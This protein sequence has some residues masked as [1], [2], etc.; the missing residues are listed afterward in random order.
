ML[1]A[2]A[3]DAAT[4]SWVADFLRDRDITRY[5]IAE[6]DLDADGR[7][8]ALIYAMDT[9]GGGEADLCGT[10]GCNLYVLSP[11]ESGYRLIANI[12]VTRP[13][14]RVLPATTHGW[15]DLGVLVAGGGI[16]GH[17]ARLRFDGAGYPSNPSVPPA[18]R[19][20]GT[21]GTIVIGQPSLDSVR[22]V[23]QIVTHLDLGSFPNSTGPRRE[24]GKKSFADYGFTVVELTDDGAA[25]YAP[26]HGWT[27]RFRIVG[28]DSSSIRVCLQDRALPRPGA[29]SNPSY[30]A[31]S[32]LVLTPSGA[33]W[34]KADEVRGGFETCAN[35]P[36]L[37][38]QSASNTAS[39]AIRARLRVSRPPLSE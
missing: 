22:A 4:P 31:R 38:S 7:P 36:P 5:R 26:D 28:R 10:G 35:D 23:H 13:P 33:P 37:Q 6:A 8:E 9:A 20:E 12:T 3:A 19:L 17:E 25:L 39:G 27:M 24:P 21:P 15:H 32:A 18:T 34:W 30:D 16:D 29:I 1:S 2:A 11:A 14:V